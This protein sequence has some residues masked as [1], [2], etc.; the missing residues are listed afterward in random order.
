[1]CKKATFCAFTL[2]PPQPSRRFP[3]HRAVQELAAS[4]TEPARLRAAPRNV[5]QPGRGRRARDLGG[6][7]LVRS[8]M[9]VH[10]RA[11]AREL[12]PSVG[13]QSDETAHLIS[14]RGQVTSFGLRG[15]LVW[16][17]DPGL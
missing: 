3:C 4:A 14:F 9:S 12:V 17:R 1:M 11:F 13:V 2:D 8:C 15:M 10:L 6:P 5:P 16:K 7:L